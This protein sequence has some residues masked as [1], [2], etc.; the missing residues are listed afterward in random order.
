MKSAT[1]EANI[2]VLTI[3]LIGLVATAGGIFIP[4]LLSNMKANSCCVEHGGQMKDGIC[5]DGD[6]LGYSV[7]ELKKVNECK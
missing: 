3:V 4:R 5:D 7:A 6:Y 2:T 1:G